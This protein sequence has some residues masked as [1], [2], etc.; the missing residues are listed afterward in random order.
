[1]DHERGDLP[2]AIAVDDDAFAVD[3][4]DVR[5][6]QLR[7]VGPVRV[8]Q[9]HVIAARN[10]VAEVIVDALVVAIQRGG[11]KGCGQV[12]PGLPKHIDP[13]LLRERH[14]TDCSS[15]SGAVSSETNRILVVR[16]WS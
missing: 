15:L 9:K 3:R 1:M 7:P 10:R 14:R 4:D 8:E 16:E 2:L 12:D 11:P 13:R 6:G 5:R